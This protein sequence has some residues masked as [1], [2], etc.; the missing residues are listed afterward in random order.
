[1]FSESI[2]TITGYLDKAI[3]D[4]T[5]EHWIQPRQRIHPTQQNIQEAFYMAKLLQLSSPQSHYLKTVPQARLSILILS[6]A[7]PF[8][9]IP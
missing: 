4:I 5:L 2:N 9:D 8:A 1:L 7:Y 3:R 6:K